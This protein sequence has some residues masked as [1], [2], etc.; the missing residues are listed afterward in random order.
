MTYKKAPSG[1]AI[2][3]EG[4]GGRRV[5]FTGMLVLPLVHKSQLID[6]SISNLPLSFR[7]PDNP[8]IAKDEQLFD[9]KI[10][11]FLRVNDTAEDVLAAA[12]HFGADSLAEL[13]E[14]I[15]ELINDAEQLVRTAAGELTWPE[16]NDSPTFKAAILQRLPMGYFKPGL[17]VDNIA[18]D[19]TDKYPPEISAHQSSSLMFREF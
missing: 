7:G 13:D 10:M 12:E 11:L 17:I 14:R 1:K 2:L 19:H 15:P 5:S 8:L 3:R 16:I 18:I 6:T 4:V 9:L